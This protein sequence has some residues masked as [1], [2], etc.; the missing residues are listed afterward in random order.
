MGK[1]TVNYSVFGHL[2]LKN[3]GI[4]SC[5]CFS[6]RKNTVNNSNFAVFSCF[7]LFFELRWSAI[8]G[9]QILRVF[10]PT[11]ST[12]GCF[13][14]QWPTS[15]AV[16]S[17]R[18]GVRTTSFKPWRPHRGSC[19]GATAIEENNGSRR[20]QW[21]TSLTV[22]TVHAICTYMIFIYIDISLYL[23]VYL[24][25]SIL[26]GRHLCQCGASRQQKP[27]SCRYDTYK[28]FKFIAQRCGAG[29]CRREATWIY[30]YIY[31]YTHVHIICTYIH[32]QTIGNQQK[33]VFSRLRIGF[34]QQ[35]CG[36]NLQNFGKHQPN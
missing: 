10:F 23:S 30:I 18:E 31:I 19:R 36:L 13:W 7:S 11:I 16:T 29:G 33:N 8:H 17:G 20:E 24:S 35:W 3:H 14:S 28:A 4:C 15:L 12:F 1:N 26:V 25:L 9:Y 2:T 34:S 21:L 22:W 6:P 5:F 32:N 27:T